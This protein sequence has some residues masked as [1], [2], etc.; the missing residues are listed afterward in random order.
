MTKAST[1]QPEH[2]TVTRKDKQP[3]RQNGTNLE[4]S[5]EVLNI[6][7]ATHFTD[8]VHAELR[9]ANVCTEERWVDE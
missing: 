6:D 9:N 4:Q 5:R 2:T 3:G 8:G 1:L 7:D